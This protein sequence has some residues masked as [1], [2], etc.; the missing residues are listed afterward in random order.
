VSDDLR[1]WLPWITSG[2]LGLILVVVLVV[3]L[4]GG[5]MVAGDSTTTILATTTTVP[6]TTTTAPIHTTTTAT[7]SET[8]TTT[9]APATDSF[10]KHGIHA[11]EECV[12]FGFDDED[13][14]AAVTEVLAAPKVDSGWVEEPQFRPPVVRTVRWNDLW[15]P[16]TQDDTVLWIEGVPHFFTYQYSGPTPELHTNE[17]IRLGS[18]LE[19]AHGGPDLAIENSPFDPD[20]GFRSY[21]LAPWTGMWDSPQGRTPQIVSPLSTVAVGTV[22]ERSIQLNRSMIRSVATSRLGT[23]M[24]G[25]ENAE[26]KLWPVLSMK[27]P[28]QPAAIAPEM[29]QS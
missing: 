27:T 8:T 25:D 12:Y 1:K 26:L 16:F 9:A 18:S 10:T 7:P 23:E 11:G 29:S 19:D 3:N 15:L 17:G 4:G 6:D 14:I 28:S 5:D 20:D 22:S 13:T 2:V 24:V 21:K